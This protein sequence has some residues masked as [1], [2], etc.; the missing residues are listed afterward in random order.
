MYTYNLQNT[1][2]KSSMPVNYYSCQPQ[3][4]MAN[5]QSTFSK[6]V[7]SSFFYFNDVHGYDSKMGNLKT[8][9]DIFTKTHNSKQ[10]DTFKVAGGDIVKGSN[11]KVNLMWVEFLNKIELD[12][13]AMGNHELDQGVKN[14]NNVIKNASYKYI[15]SNTQINPQGVFSKNIKNGKILKS[16]VENKNGHLYGFVGLSPSDA[17]YKKIDA[18]LNNKDIKSSDNK[19]SLAE[20][21]KEVNKLKQKGINKIILLSHFDDDDNKIS[22]NVS[23]IDIIISGH[24]HRV[25]NGIVPG[26]N[27]FTSPA[28][29]PVIKVEGGRDNKY[30]G[31]LDVIFDKN[32]IITN[33]SNALRE[34]NSIP[35][36]LSVLALKLKYKNDEKPVG[37]LHNSITP[38]KFSENVLAGFVADAV[39]KKSGADIVLFS[40]D[41][42]NENFDKGIITRN[43]LEKNLPYKDKLHKVT[44]SEK[45]LID[46]LRTVAIIIKDNSA[47][48]KLFQ[49]SG[50]RFTITLDG[51][52]K[53]V[54]LETPQKKLILLN[55]EKPVTN[56][57]FTVVYDDFI[58]KTKDVLTCFKKPSEEEFGWDKKDA[59]IEEVKNKHFIPFDLVPQ[60][61]I[62]IDK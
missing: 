18:K 57:K 7:K 4:S 9:A 46:T 8:A 25:Y 37:I 5:V 32:G 50:L 31:T 15:S 47:S 13:A 59:A 20:L 56:K 29:K 48:S 28:G 33:A 14:F 34:T 11:Q 49:I 61:R 51:N 22:K 1:N 36:D 42:I 2:P 44:L 43:M 54:N 41:S 12:F 24:K 19:T 21:Q 55:W 39:R 38:E 23:G 27:F 35:E 17:K 60:N 52:L 53:D 30:T 62:K 45:E 26:R 3:Y 40:S 58:L 6:P 16:W 10:I